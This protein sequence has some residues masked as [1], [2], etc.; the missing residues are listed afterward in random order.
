[1]ASPI[2][3]AIH[4]TCDAFTLQ[5]ARHYSSITVDAFVAEM[6]WREVGPMAIGMAGIAPHLP[7]FN[8]LDGV[9][10]YIHATIGLTVRIVDGAEGAIWFDCDDWLRPFDGIRHTMHVPRD[11][12]AKPLMIRC[13]NGV[14]YG[15]PDDDDEGP[16]LPS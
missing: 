13:V 6:L 5:T 11:G 4:A 12:Q 14:I 8:P 1:M 16:V 9:R 10:E 15:L 3:D 2:L 7:L